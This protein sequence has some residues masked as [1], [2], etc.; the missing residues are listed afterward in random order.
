MYGLAALASDQGIARMKK[1]WLAENDFDVDDNDDNSD[2][3]ERSWSKCEDS[4]D[5][6]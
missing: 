6:D 2:I 5:S 4:W 3:D 1:R